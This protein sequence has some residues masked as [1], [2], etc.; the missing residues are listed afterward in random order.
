MKK[1][2]L[3]P[4]LL[5]FVLQIG[6][7]AP[8]EEQKPEDL[9]TSPGQSEQSAPEQTQELL[10]QMKRSSD[11]TDVKSFLNQLKEKVATVEYLQ[12]ISVAA[13]TVPN[14]SLSNSLRNHDVVRQVVSNRN[15]DFRALWLTGKQPK[16]REIKQFMDQEQSTSNN[17]TR[18]ETKNDSIS[19]LKEELQNL[20]TFRENARRME[21]GNTDARGTM[22]LFTSTRIR[23]NERSLILH[24]LESFARTKIPSMFFAGQPLTEVDV[25]KKIRASTSNVSY[26]GKA[27]KQH[28]KIFQDVNRDYIASKWTAIGV[29]GGGLAGVGALA[30]VPLLSGAIN[31]ISSSVLASLGFISVQGLVEEHLADYFPRI[32][33]PF[34]STRN[35]RIDDTSETKALQ[36]ENISVSHVAKLRGASVQNEDGNLLS[37]PLKTIEQKTGGE[38]IPSAHSSENFIRHSYLVNQTLHQHLIERKELFTS[39]SD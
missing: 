1:Y 19:T 27:F 21:L 13:I 5:A 31:L 9:F 28:K 26:S 29:L 33:I 23:E 3:L 38:A 39:V 15:T 10:V 36:R 16:I 30:G 2:V 20:N 24:A 25:A 32:P 4:V 35:P 34:T 8:A 37:N 7:T 14:H 11:Q 22:A 6:L 18:N 17:G 12:E